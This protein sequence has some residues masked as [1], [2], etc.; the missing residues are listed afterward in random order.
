[1]A[2]FREFVNEQLLI[3]AQNYMEEVNALFGAAAL[4][5]TNYTNCYVDGG[6]INLVQPF[7]KYIEEK[8]GE[9]QYRNPI[10]SIEKVEEKYLVHNKKETLS[11]EYFISG[12]PINNTLSLYKSLPAKKFNNKLMSSPQLN[13]AF[14]MGIGFYSDQKFDTIHHQ[15]HL[16]TPL[17]GTKSDSIFVSL[18][19]PEDTNRCD[20]KGTRVM[21]VSTHLKDPVNNMID[22]KEAERAVIVE[23][24]KQGFLQEEDILY[25]HASTQKSWEKWTG[26][27]FGFVGGYP[28]FKNIKPWQMIGSKLDNHKAYICGDTTYPGQGIPG[29]TLSGIIASNRLKDDWLKK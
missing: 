20:L 10:L 1:D 15:L 11:S 29:V 25:K 24:V 18:N 7:I 9:I 2:I 27:A 28:Q 23:L 13:S 26:R 12:L 3:T 4:C 21:S 22:K 14:Q 16:R 8:G 6:L 19:H 5:Y 17:P